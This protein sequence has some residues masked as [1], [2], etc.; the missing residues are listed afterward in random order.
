MNR[1]PNSPFPPL[2]LSPSAACWIE[3]NRAALRHN[4]A[5][6]QNL[7]GETKIIA[8]V[9]AN[10]FGCGALECSRVFAESGAEMLAVTRVEEA[11][12][13][14]KGGIE[15]P[16]LLL[17]PTPQDELETVAELGLIALISNLEEAQALDAI[18]Q[19]MGFVASTHL[20]INTGMNRFGVRPDGVAEIVGRSRK[21]SNLKI[22]AAFTHFANASAPDAAPTLAQFEEFQNATCGL[23]AM[24]FHV[25]NSAA[26]LRFPPMRLD[27]VRPGTLLYGQFP[28]PELGKNSGLKL[29]DPFSVKAK[30]VAIQSLKKGEKFGYGSEWTAP[31]DQKIAIL[32]VGFADGLSMEPN[33]RALSPL[34]AMKA[35]IERAARLKKNPHAGRTVT[36]RERKAPIIGRIAMQTCALDVSKIEGIQLGD[37]ATVPM[38]RLAAGQ[39]LPRVYVDGA[40]E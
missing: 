27:F 17:S 2:S 37:I 34:Q 14:R 40:S 3:I 26:T 15:A 6:I 38:R 16:V 31:N 9:K 29:R 12:E 4:F 23:K 24:K 5:Q 32:A 21:L 1:E 30:V 25:A 22:E 11:A 20:K 13:L 39:N 7:V 18:A 33:A 19:K 8:V 35:G 36:I 28:T 10:A